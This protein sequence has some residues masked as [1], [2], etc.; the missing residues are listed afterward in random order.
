MTC[1]ELKGARYLLIIHGVR[2][3]MDFFPCRGEEESKRLA[4]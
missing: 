2:V 1:H 4:S 3:A